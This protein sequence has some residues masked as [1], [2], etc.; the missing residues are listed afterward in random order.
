[1]PFGRFDPYSPCSRKHDCGRSNNGT[2]SFQPAGSER[3]VTF[4]SNFDKDE[5]LISRVQRND[6]PHM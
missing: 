6:Y 1:M 4:G 3:I 5:A 2:D